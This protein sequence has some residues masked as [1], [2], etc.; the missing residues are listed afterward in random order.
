MELDPSTCLHFL[1]AATDKPMAPAPEYRST[2]DDPQGTYFC[3]FLSKEQKACIC[4]NK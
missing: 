2:T 1:V 3:N 4:A